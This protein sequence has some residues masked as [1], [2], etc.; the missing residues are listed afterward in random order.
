[1]S[2]SLFPLKANDELRP[3]TLSPLTF[4]K[5]LSSSSVMPSLKYSSLL[6]ALIFTNGKTATLFFGVAEPVRG[7]SVAAFS[8]LEMALCT[9][10]VIFLASS[11]LMVSAKDEGDGIAGT[12]GGDAT[13]LF[14]SDRRI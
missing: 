7:G 8:F 12:G 3:G 1:M 2:S 6:S 5:A 4:V 9:S 11:P 10:S 14:R 13:W